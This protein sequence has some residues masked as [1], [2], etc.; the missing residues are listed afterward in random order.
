ML[1]E[2]PYLEEIII[3]RIRVYNPNY[4]DL[5]ICKCRH[6]YERHFDSYEKMRAVGCKY[7]PC[8][9]FEEEE[10]NHVQRTALS[11]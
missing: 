4:G 8:F 5:R 10:V 6:P 7:C 1:I 11:F 3:K 2:Q 9:D